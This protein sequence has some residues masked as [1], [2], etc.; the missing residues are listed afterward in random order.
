M[1]NGKRVYMYSEGYCP[2]LDD[3]CRA[4]TPAAADESQAEQGKKQ[5]YTYA[6]MRIHRQ[7]RRVDENGRVYLESDGPKPHA[8]KESN[9]RKHQSESDD[10]GIDL[11]IKDRAISLEHLMTHY[12]KNPHCKT[13]ERAKM[14]HAPTPNRSNRPSDDSREV[15]ENFGDAVTGDH[16]I[17]KAD[18]EKGID[19]QKAGLVLFDIGT[20]YVDI[21]PMVERS[22]DNCIIAMNEFA[23]GN[24]AVKSFYSDGASEIEVAAKWLG[25]PFGSSTPGRHETNGIAENKVK[26]VNNGTRTALVHGGLSERWWPYTSRHFL[27]W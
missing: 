8:R 1:P 27:L 18:D 6:S 16:V 25:W 5:T 17:A 19:G 13:C 24:T 9:K 23:G 12:P 21:F 4:A 11:R 26:L 14:Q 10:A 22:S 3:T 20:E 7:R 2:Y 15:A